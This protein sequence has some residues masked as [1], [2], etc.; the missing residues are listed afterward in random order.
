[1]ADSILSYVL[2]ASFKLLFYSSMPSCRGSLY[3]ILEKTVMDHLIIIREWHKNAFPAYKILITLSSY[4]IIPPTV[5]DK[6]I[7]R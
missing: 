3:N 5:N 7:V 6:G 1:M 4:F 2:L